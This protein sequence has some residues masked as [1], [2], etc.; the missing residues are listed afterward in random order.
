M[1]KT[2]LAPNY[3]KRA[4]RAKFLAHFWA[5][6]QKFGNSVEN[7]GHFCTFCFISAV[8]SPVLCPN[9]CRFSARMFDLRKI[10]RGRAFCPL[11]PASYAY[12][13]RSENIGEDT[14]E[15]NRKREVSVKARK[16]MSA[17]ASLLHCDLLKI[18]NIQN[19]KIFL[20]CSG[21]R[22]E[23]PCFMFLQSCSPL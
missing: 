10:G 13:E 9:F 8:F 15:E 17:N 23:I 11:T 4:E 7:L 6:E 21:T 1:A 20:K 14:E 18:P 5:F 2:L 16:N 3:Y 19:K 22:K 12:V